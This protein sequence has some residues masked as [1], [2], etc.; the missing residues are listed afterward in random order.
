M[1]LSPWPPQ[2]IEEKRRQILFEASSMSMKLEDCRKKK[3]DCR[4]A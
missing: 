1:P 4:I 2:R 3:R